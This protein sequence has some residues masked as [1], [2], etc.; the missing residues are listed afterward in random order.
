M[1]RKLLKKVMLMVSGTRV[2]F[3]FFFF[4][5]FFYIFDI[6]HTKLNLNKSGIQNKPYKNKCEQKRNSILTL[7]IKNNVSLCKCFFACEC[8]L[9]VCGARDCVHSCIYVRG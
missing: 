9:C 6:S 3:R 2:F 7:H 8:V 5:F 1:K 4:F